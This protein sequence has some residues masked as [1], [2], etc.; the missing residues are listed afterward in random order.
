MR[1][2][3]N[4]RCTGFSFFGGLV[5]SNLAGWL[6]HLLGFGVSAVRL[7]LLARCIS[8]FVSVSYEVATILNDLA[9][10]SVP[11]ARTLCAAFVTSL[12]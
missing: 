4:S 9:G 10:F 11:F 5:I 8:W 7:L 3:K 6:C 2:R 12:P 1:A